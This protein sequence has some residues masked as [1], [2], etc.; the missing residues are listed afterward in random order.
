MKPT[1]KLD[2]LIEGF[3]RIEARLTEISGGAAPPDT[4]SDKWIGDAGR[5][6]RNPDHPAWNAD[7][8]DFSKIDEIK[9]VDIEG[10]PQHAGDP[11]GTYVVKYGGFSYAIMVMPDIDF[12]VAHRASGNSITRLLELKN[13]RYVVKKVARLHQPFKYTQGESRGKP[14]LVLQVSDRADCG[15]IYATK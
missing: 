10:I 14:V 1:E 4:S 8:W 11:T 3:E 5:R 15:T 2:L 9:Q 12:T 13:G 6:R 7:L